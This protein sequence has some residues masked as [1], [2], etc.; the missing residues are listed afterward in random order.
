MEWFLWISAVDCA[1]RTLSSDA[2]DSLPKANPAAAAAGAGEPPAPPR[3]VIGPKRSESITA[4]GLAPMVKMSRRIPP[5]PVVAPW[6]GSM[7][8]GCLCDLILKA[9]AQPSPM[10]MMPAF[11]P[12]PCTTSLLRVGRRF[13]WTRE[14]LE[15]QCSLPIQ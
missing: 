11:S 7:K 13:R 3:V 12:G 2:F 14:G 1:D 8:L 6:N 4:T 5:T 9:Q 15:E 10:S